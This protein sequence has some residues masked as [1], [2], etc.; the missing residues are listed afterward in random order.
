MKELEYIDFLKE[1]DERDYKI[2]R[3]QAK[4]SKIAAELQKLKSTNVAREV[5]KN[6]GL[7]EFNRNLQK[8]NIRLK[9]Q[10]N[11]LQLKIAKLKEL[12]K[13]SSADGS[14]NNKVSYRTSIEAEMAISTIQR[15]GKLEDNFPHR[16]YKCNLCKEY[17]LTS[18][19]LRR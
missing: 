7:K 13:V 4:N 9:D 16:Y 12:N 10:V 3:L 5:D 19:K 14:C 8:E 1:L 6:K 17:H 15:K 11:K 2:E 18:K